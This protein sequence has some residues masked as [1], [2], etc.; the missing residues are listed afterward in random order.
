MVS[1]DGGGDLEDALWSGHAPCT[2][3]ENY[4]FG[5]TYHS[6]GLGARVV[7]ALNPA[8]V[9]T[10]L[11][12]YD[13]GEDASLSLNQY[14]DLALTFTRGDQMVELIGIDIRISPPT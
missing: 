14:T 11:A 3:H 4:S 6:A 10:S 5:V 12:P 7:S 8:M 9:M 13:N 1:E 2:V